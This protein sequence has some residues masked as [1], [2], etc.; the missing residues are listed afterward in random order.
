MAKFRPVIIRP[1]HSLPQPKKTDEH[2]RPMP[3]TCFKVK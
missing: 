1:T 3:G 2:K